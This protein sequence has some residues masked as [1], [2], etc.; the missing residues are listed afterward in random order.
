MR[1]K[2]V[3]VVPPCV[4]KSFFGKR[5]GEEVFFSRI[6]KELPLGALTLATYVRE[7]SDAVTEVLDLNLLIAE[8]YEKGHIKGE[9]DAKRIIKGTISGQKEKGFDFA[10][11]SAI[12]NPTFGWLD[13]ISSCLK[14]T[15]PGIIILAGG[16]IP[17]NLPK[18][19]FDS[20]PNIDYISYGEGELAIC[21]IVT[22]EDE[23]KYI[24]NSISIYSREKIANEWKAQF[25]LIEDLD[26]IPTLDF[27]LLELQK[28]DHHSKPQSDIDIIAA[29]LMF[30]RG[31]PFNCCFCASHSVHG[32]RVRWNSLER[33]EH[34]LREVVRDYNVNAVEVWDD[35]FFVD[36]E[37][38]IRLMA[39]FKELHLFVDF[40]NSLP[41]YQIDDTIASMLKEGGIEVVSL[42]I[43]SG[44]PRVLREIIHKPLKLEMVPKAIEILRKYDFYIQGL[45]VI[46]FPGETLEDIE[47]TMEFIHNCKLNWVNIFV[48]SPLPGSE[49]MEKCIE[50]GYLDIDSVANIAFTK[51]SI[52]TEH[53][54]AHDIE[55]IQ[56]YNTIKKDFVN[57]Q[58]MKDGNWERALKNFGYVIDANYE[59]PFAYYYAAKC[60]GKLCD[61]NS[62][63]KYYDC[64]RKI[65]ET[66]VGYRK[67]WNQFISE[68]V[69]FY[70][71]SSCDI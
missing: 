28:Y 61:K 44:N 16:G 32:K 42:A 22:A 3:F 9:E 29:P 70:P 11:I 39:L 23:R 8:E 56:Q 31:C 24:N 62:A 21:G 63:E 36:K 25:E 12:F 34:D 65:I 20:S 33:I 53:W 71:V 35:N 69:S 55:E 54:S 1:K 51:G 5:S 47:I 38:A 58:D 66:N 67:L 27:S 13:L 14:E 18:E 48:A 52:S 64:C 41:V 30:S 4:D 40:S 46:G 59:N 26:D 6:R 43:E 49:L 60:C 45:F 57:N 68:G 19:V 10:G 37:K 15:F 17:T 7:Y 2:C 50:G